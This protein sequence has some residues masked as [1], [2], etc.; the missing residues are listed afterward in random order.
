[1]TKTTCFSGNGFFLVCECEKQVVDVVV[2]LLF[3]V[4]IIMWE[5]LE[6]GSSL[7]RYLVLSVGVL[8]IAIT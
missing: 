6:A 7:I 1:M 2:F 4:L 3:Y 5:F 8:Q